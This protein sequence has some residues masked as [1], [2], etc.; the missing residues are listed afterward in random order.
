MTSFQVKLSFEF[1]ILFWR[2]ESMLTRFYHW[3]LKAH[4]GNKILD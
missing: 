1:K 4:R 2:S 3:I